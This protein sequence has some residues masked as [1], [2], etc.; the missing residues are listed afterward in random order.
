MMVKLSCKTYTFQLRLCINLH[1]EIITFCRKIVNA[2]SL[3]S[4]NH[5]SC[6][7]RGNT[8]NREF[9]TALTKKVISF[10]NWYHEKW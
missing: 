8:I 10:T 9:V 7:E 6:C 4:T 5:G 1:L 3:L 2:D